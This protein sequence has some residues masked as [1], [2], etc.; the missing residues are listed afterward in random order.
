MDLITRDWVFLMLT[1]S[2]LILINH[3]FIKR[4]W[5]STIMNSIA[6]LVLLFSIQSNTKHLYSR[7]G[8]I[9]ISLVVVLASLFFNN[10]IE[11]IEKANET[12]N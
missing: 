11:E 2:L 5:L 10:K 7:F 1:A 9:A 12:K 4:N 3:L 8:G 6:F